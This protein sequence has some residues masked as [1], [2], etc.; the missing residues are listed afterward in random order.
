MNDPFYVPLLQNK[1]YHNLDEGG[2]QTN[3]EDVVDDGRHSISSIQKRHMMYNHTKTNRQKHWREACFIDLNDCYEWAGPA[4]W[5]N[6]S[7]KIIHGSNL[8]PHGR[9]VMFFHRPDKITNIP[10]HL[11]RDI[12]EDMIEYGF[13]LPH[14]IP[15]FTR[16]ICRDTGEYIVPTMCYR[17]VLAS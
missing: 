15:L 6:G 5:F 14:W 11:K 17:H 3:K 16:H 7:I 4:L 12:Y 13:L 9:E 1:S 2:T 10:A 8:F